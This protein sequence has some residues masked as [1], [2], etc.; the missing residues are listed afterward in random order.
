M[1]SFARSTPPLE[2]PMWL[3]ANGLPFLVVGLL[4]LAILAF[5]A[6]PR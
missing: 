1:S 2:V 4:I 6:T 3:I 5:L